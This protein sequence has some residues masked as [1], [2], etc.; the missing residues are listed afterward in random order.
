MYE[1]IVSLSGTNR[2]R[3]VPYTL[4]AAR[5][6]HIFPAQLLEENIKKRKD[7]NFSSPSLTKVGKIIA[8]QP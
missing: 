1:C 5:L 6:E 2:T 3:S 7:Y 8:I 4:K